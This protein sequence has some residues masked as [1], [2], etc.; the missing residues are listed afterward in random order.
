MSETAGEGVDSSAAQESQ[1]RS[2]DGVLERLP[3]TRPQRTSARRAAARAGS[4]GAEPAP[5][6]EAD[7]PDAP[8]ATNARRASGAAPRKAPARRGSTQPSRAKAA[9]A[10][11]RTGAPERD[12]PSR[13]PAGETARTAAPRQG[14]ESEAE[15]TRSIQPPNGIELIGSAVEIVGELTKAGLSKSEHLLKDV[16]SRLPH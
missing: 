1:A 6:A 3:R 13:R 14:F 5:G 15:S 10:R 9:S 8:G 4:E 7:S 2:D 11:A 16:L 12:R